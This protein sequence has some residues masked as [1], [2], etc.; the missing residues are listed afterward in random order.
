MDL[1]LLVHSDDLAGAHAALVKLGYRRYHLSRGFSRY[2]SGLKSLGEV[3]LQHAV[4][5]PSRAMLRRATRRG[6]G[7][8]RLPVPV[9]RP[10]DLIG[11]K[12]QAVVNDPRGR[13]HDRADIRALARVRGP[14]WNLVL[15]YYRLFG[16][17]R[18][19]VALRRRVRRG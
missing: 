8:I 3:D 18:E 6:A 7:G 12:L 5:P 13:E 10:E 14:D 17:L 15:G 11:L 4:L 2:E 16:R 1:D 19:G 9:L